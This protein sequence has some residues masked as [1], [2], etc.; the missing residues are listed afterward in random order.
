MDRNSIQ[1]KNILNASGLKAIGMGLNFI[2]VPLLISVLGKAEYGIWVTVF[3]IINWI[4]TFDLGFGQGLRNKLTESLSKNDFERSNKLISTTYLIITII[5]IIFFLVG[6]L[7][8][9]FSNPNEILNYY[10][11]EGNSLKLFIFVAFTFTLLNF[12]L[13]LYKK[14]LLADHKSYIIE[15]VNTLFLLTFV[16]FVFI[17][18]WFGSSNT[19]ITLMI[20]FGGLNALFAIG[21]TIY[22]F[23]SNSQ[24]RFSTDYFSKELINNLL[25]TGASFF[26]IQASI[27][28]IF[29]TDNIIISYLLGPE[30]VTDYSVVQKL[31]QIFVVVYSTILIPSWG[32][33]VHAIVKNDYNW[34][35]SNLKKMIKIFTLI[36]LVGLV[37][38]INT[39]SIIKLWVGN[40]VHYPKYLDILLYIYAMV[41]N[42]SNIFMYFINATGKLKLQSLLYTIGA[43]INIPLSIL[44]V[45][46]IGSSTGVILATI[47]SILPLLLFMPFQAIKYIREMKN[48]NQILSTQKKCFK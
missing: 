19:L 14:L 10:N 46:I 31:F 1:I 13:S 38:L 7:L 41:F 22:F 29:S 4:F 17:Y 11:D 40:K 39:S 34:I 8:L 20:Y 21:S 18:K 3:S 9:N 44:F 30:A 24:L 26:L 35:L 12:I 2:L 27:L 45:K 15:L 23:R 32:L 5:A 48:E 37:V 43:L 16:S 6:T 25:K 28:I 47:I 42:F 36:F 33:Y